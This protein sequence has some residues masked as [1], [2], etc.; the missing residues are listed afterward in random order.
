M[1]R[2]AVWGLGAMGSSIARLAAE[3]RVAEITAALDVSPSK[4]GRTLDQVAGPPCPRVPV[5][6]ADQAPESLRK[7]GVE[8]VFLATSSYL[9]DVAPQILTALESGSSVV[10][11]AE[12]M[13]YPWAADPALAD[14]IHRVAVKVG[15]GVLGIGVNPGYV[16]D[17]LPLV[18]SGPCR[19]VDKVKV[20][21]CNDLSPY[22]PAVLRSQGVGLDPEEFED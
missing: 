8:L 17:L 5:D 12:E 19:R 22:G 2:A 9:R 18:F 16:M 1:R 3:R 10:T 14:R 20:F 6:H 11:I 21:R 15:R 7:A 13:I 4:V